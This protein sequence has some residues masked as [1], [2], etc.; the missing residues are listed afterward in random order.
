M[1]GKGKL[2]GVG[3]LNSGQLFGRRGTTVLGERLTIRTSTKDY[4]DKISKKTTEQ[5]FG[6]LKRKLYFS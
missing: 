3:E 2:R 5:L 1:R 6:R 4:S